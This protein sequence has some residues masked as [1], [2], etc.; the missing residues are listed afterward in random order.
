LI[1]H[2]PGV[3]YRCELE[4]P[5]RM[6]YVS[7]GVQAMSGHSVDD[8][9]S[10][11]L[12]W[13]DIMASEDLVQ[14]AAAVDHAVLEHKSFDVTYRLNSADGSER[15]V[16]ERGRAYYDGDKPKFLEGFIWDIS[17]AK[18]AEAHARWIAN[19]DALTALPNRVLLQETVEVKIA[20]PNP[21]FAIVLLDVDDFKR[22]ND[23][24]GHAAG[25]TLLQEFATRLTS[26]VGA[27]GLVAR[28]GGD[29]FAILVE[30]ADLDTIMDLGKRIFEALSMPIR[31]SLG[32]LACSA[33]VGASIFGV[34]GRNWTELLKHADIALYAAKAAGRGNLKVFSNSMRN[35][36]QARTSMLSLAG[37]AIENSRI[38]PY[39]QPQVDLKSG[40]VVG[41]EALLRWQDVSGSL[42]LPET[43]SA[44]FDDPILATQLSHRMIE[45]VVGDMRSWLD[46][47]VSFGHVAINA[48]P[49]EFRTGD[50]ADRLLQKLHRLNVPPHLLHVEVT[51]TVFLGRGSRY[52]EEALKT[53]N[54][55]GVCIALDDFGTGYA[56]LLHLAQYPVRVLK[57]DRSFVRRMV[58]SNDDDAIIQAVIGLGHSL[59]MKV[60]A[61][62]VE[63]L[64][65]EVRLRAKG[66]NFGQ[67]F[68]Y[69]QAMPAADVAALGSACR[70][71]LAR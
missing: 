38:I 64:E 60:V 12:G 16:Q 9:I 48:S 46:D 57:I 37:S 52:V 61:E 51:E 25:D 36:I 71:S 34:H 49:A 63:T 20:A 28:L 1:N 24:L 26:V 3:A 11:Q 8:F 45:R 10:G 33:S 19:H 69:A 13:A 44:A 15:W 62:G 21:E 18:C 17:D 58:S 53:L 39:Y 54:G 42:R 29:E 70:S 65:Q 32:P 5:W 43:I 2:L 66:C 41:F 40:D 6:T 4:E 7:E 55:A 31:D 30:A 50:F 67:G 35:E 27:G 23:T 22:T 59:R 47:G 14:V 56:S 68:L